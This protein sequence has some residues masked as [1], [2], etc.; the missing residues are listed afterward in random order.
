M[1]TIFLL[2]LG[3]IF[4]GA[5]FSNV[6]KWRNKDRVLKDLQN[7]HSTFEMQDGKRIWGKTHIYSNGMELLFSREAQNSSGDPITSY[8]FYNDDIDRIRAIY[9]NHGELSL[10]NQQRRKKEIKD[11]SDPDFLA[12][13]YRKLRIAFN[14]F[15][16]AIGEAFSVFLSRMKGGAMG[17]S[18]LTTQSDYLKKLGTTAL[19]AVGNTYD[20]IMERYINRRVVISLKD[21]V[22]EDE[23]CGFLKEYS[24]GWLSIVDCKVTHSH[25]IALDDIERLSLQRD[26]DFHY[27]LSKKENTEQLSLQIDITY[28]GREPLKLL[29][30]KG[31]NYLHKINKTLNH[32]QSVSLTLDKLSQTAFKTFDTKILPIQFEMVSEERQQLHLQ[33]QQSSEKNHIYQSILPS[34]ELEYTLTHTADVY[35][36]RTLAILRHSSE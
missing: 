28:H 24:S 18:I 15:N 30:I 19:S 29:A 27:L 17:G 4:L 9:R 3:I 20:P 26:M 25:N 23:F 8:I 7:F 10:E 12:I 1:D 34:F 5:L 14:M 35:V 16:D 2:T 21:T 6:L 22:R 36:P 33:E 13:A 11:V 31:E 32:D